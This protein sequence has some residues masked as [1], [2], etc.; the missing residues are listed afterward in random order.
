MHLC[1]SFA[2]S[3]INNLPDSHFLNITLGM[4]H[5]LLRGLVATNVSLYHLHSF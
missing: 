5:E 2:P 3:I 1:L 4:E